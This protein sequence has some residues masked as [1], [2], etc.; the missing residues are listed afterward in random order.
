MVIVGAGPV[1]S[2]AALYA[3]QR[4]YNVEVYELRPDPR[5]PGSGSFG[6]AR[7]M[8]LTISE[9]GM[10]AL[11]KAEQPDL[12]QRVID[13]SIPFENNLAIDCKDLTC[14]LLDS[15]DA[16]SN[17]KIF[18]NHKFVRVNFHGTALFEDEDWLSHSAEVKFDMMLGADGAHS[19]V[20]YNMKVSCRD[21]QH[22]YIDLFWC[23]F[24]IKPGKAH[25]DGARGWKIMPNCLHIWPAGDFTFIAIPNKDGYLPAPSS[26]QR[27]SLPR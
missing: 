23:E 8:N 14:A 26:C 9:R 19:T 1:G 11:R 4:G 18:F 10:K 7:S 15:L 27:V 20:R 2:L 6:T 12:L 17:I 16:L 3:A 13:A 24:N 22:E 25:N 5:R 21:Y